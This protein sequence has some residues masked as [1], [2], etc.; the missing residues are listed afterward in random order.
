MTFVKSFVASLAAATI[1]ATGA[2]AQQSGGPG[3]GSGP[4]GPPAFGGAPQP[5]VV[6]TSVE[7]LRSERAG[8]LEVVRVRGLTTSGAWGQPHLIPVTQGPPLDGML[9]LVFQASAPTSAQRL[10]PFMV[11]ESILPVES[12][13]PYKGVR[14]RAGLNALSLMV[15][16]GYVEVAAPKEDCSKCIGKYFVSKGATPP[17]GATAENSVREADLPYTV[18][19]IRPADGIASY[20]YDANRLTLLLAEDGR[21][22]DGAWD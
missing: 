7:V 3:N 1:L 14:V 18:R 21:I 11:V 16:P 19:A 8:S 22:I 4:G 17:A 13:H 5:V 15:L 20:Q 2:L 10:G 12:K 9:D 6:V